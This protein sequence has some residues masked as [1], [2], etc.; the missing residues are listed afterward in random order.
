MEGWISMHRKITENEFYFCERFT[1]IQAFIDLLILAN[2]KPSTFFV[3]YNE[4]ALK[5][6][7]LGYSIE[8]LAIRW[9]WNKR[10]VK[11]YLNMLQKR[12]MIHYRTSK[13]TTIISIKNY[14]FY[15]NGA[16]Q[17]T[18]Q[19][20]HRVHTYNNDKNIKKPSS[21]GSNATDTMKILLGRNNNG[22]N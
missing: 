21:I 9:K 5:R 22:T 20:I 11:K 7:E 6:G 18:P 16:R 10:T 14:E 17:N 4:V 2:H 3:R 12:E 13:I 1:K 15:Q 19:S 8:T